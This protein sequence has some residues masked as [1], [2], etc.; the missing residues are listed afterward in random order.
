MIVARLV[1]VLSLL[2]VIT[3]PVFGWF[4]KDWAG[5]TTLAVYWF[6]TVAAS[7]FICAR[8][9]FQSR[10]APRR[11]H[12]AYN[13]PSAGRRGSKSSSFLA[14]FA[15]VSFAFSAAHAVFLAA[16]LLLL[17]HNGKGDLAGVD[18][19]SV[20]FGCLSVLAFLALDFVVDL[21]TLRQWSF[22]Q[23]EQLADRGL[24]RVIVVHLTLIIGFVGIAVTGAPDALFGVFVVLKTLA[25]LNAVVPQWEPATAPQ[26]LSRI[27]NRV[28]NVLP[29]ERFE[30]FWTEDRTEELERRDRNEAPWKR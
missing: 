28:P 6:E 25:A 19:R 24:S 10:W 15:I 13:A 16:I 17:H 26:W 29:G 12:F 2:G 22:R 30:V 8:I 7:L 21:F 20:G 18:W 11:G 5:G 1:H 4:V 23:L 27:M 9:V 3:V 14:G